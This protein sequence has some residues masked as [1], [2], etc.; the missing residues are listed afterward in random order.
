MSGTW[1]IVDQTKITILGMDI[2]SHL[3]YERA[4]G[5]DG[6]TDYYAE[7]GFV[8][9]NPAYFENISLLLRKL[10]KW[11][12]MQTL[13]NCHSIKQTMKGFGMTWRTHLVP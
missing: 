8:Q 2:K 1:A 9:I 7:E 11:E 6:V 4:L 3:T 12:K 13:Q 5:R 10:Y